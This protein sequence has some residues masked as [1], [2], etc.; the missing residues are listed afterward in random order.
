MKS[1]QLAKMLITLMETQWQ[2]DIPNVLAIATM[3]CNKHQGNRHEVS[4]ENLPLRYFKQI[5]QR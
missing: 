4:V 2:L 3:K 5:Y 1:S